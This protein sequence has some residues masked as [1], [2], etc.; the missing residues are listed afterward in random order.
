MVSGF[1]IVIGVAALVFFLR[2]GLGVREH[3]V[4]GLLGRLPVGTVEL[5]AQKGTALLGF[6][7]GQEA[8]G[9]G[10][11]IAIAKMERLAAHPEVA[12][13][14]ERIRVDFPMIAWGLQKELRLPKPVAVDVFASGLPQEWVAGDVAAGKSF[15][16]PGQ[17][18]PIPVLLSSKL[19]AMANSALAATL[20]IDVTPKLIAGLTFQVMLGRSYM[21]GGAKSAE[22]TRRVTC[23]IVGVSDRATTL[24]FS[25]PTAVAARWNEEFGR[26]ARPVERAWVV[27]KSPE[28]LGEVVAQARSLGIAVD[29]SHRVVGLAVD[30]VLAILLLVAALLLALAAMIVSQT[31]YTRVALRRAEY[32]LY[33]ALGARRSTIVW[34]VLAEA[35]GVG[36]LCGLLGVGLANGFGAWLE[37]LALAA[38]ADLPMA[39][40]ALLASPAFA[41]VIGLVTAIGFALCGALRPALRAATTDPA[42]SLGL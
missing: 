9:L 3:I 4:T 20:R 40:E 42:E 15:V 27:L 37:P 5:Q 26:P 23:E 12:A 32:G 7:T 18:R 10:P 17:G 6:L 41:S 14:H 1:G 31:F 29:E 24:G 11:T 30:A 22:K 36:L 39:P 8:K 16:D 19:L 28:K 34:V 33:R 35:A 25:V 13:V 21:T 2:I 38:A